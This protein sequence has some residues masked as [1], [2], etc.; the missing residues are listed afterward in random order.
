MPTLGHA[1]RVCGLTGSCSLPSAA[2]A[3]PAGCGA[4]GQSPRGSLHSS[5]GWL[6]HPCRC[7]GE[8]SSLTSFL[9]FFLF[10]S[11]PC[12]P[13]T[14]SCTCHVLSP[15]SICFGSQL[16]AVGGPRG[17]L[18]RLHHVRIF[19]LPSLCT[20]CADP[21]PMA[22]AGELQPCPAA[23]AGGGVLSL[24]PTPPP[25][26]PELQTGCLHRTS[27]K[28][29]AGCGWLLWLA[30]AGVSASAVLFRFPSREMQRDN[31]LQRVHGC[32]GGRMRWAQANTGRGEGDASAESP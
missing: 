10:P 32:S 26:L 1:G 11:S 17:Q 20:C 28:V 12:S 8:D 13:D 15:C 29:R 22:M 27:P 30:Q 16:L 31:R 2:G 4:W 25:L 3:E 5:K 7:H 14:H 9:H 23:L 19:L 24:A 21:H 6:D 18:T